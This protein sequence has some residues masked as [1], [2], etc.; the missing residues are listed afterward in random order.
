MDPK[1]LEKALFWRSERAAAQL[2]TGEHW[3]SMTPEK[4]ARIRK[5][6]TDLIDR[7]AFTR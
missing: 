4:K 3:A 5:E 1:D 7:E 6:L 2:F